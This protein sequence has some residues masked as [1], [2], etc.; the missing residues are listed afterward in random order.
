MAKAV[1]AGNFWTRVTL[2]TLEPGDADGYGERALVATEQGTVWADV[3]GIA[4]RELWYGQKVNPECAYGVTIRMWDGGNRPRLTSSW[5][6]V[7][8]GLT[9]EIDS[10]VDDLARGVQRLQCKEIVTE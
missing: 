7:W 4:G 10:V 8:N 1:A 5:Q 6:V 2:Q 9:L 3:D